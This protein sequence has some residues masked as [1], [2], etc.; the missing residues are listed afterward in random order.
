MTQAQCVLDIS[1]LYCIKCV[2][3]RGHRSSSAYLAMFNVGIM[4]PAT[5]G[6]YTCVSTSLFNCLLIFIDSADIATCY[7]TVLGL[8]SVSEMNVVINLKVLLLTQMVEFHL[9]CLYIQGVVPGGGGT[10][11]HCCAIVMT[12]NCIPGIPLSRR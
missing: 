3:W 1:E 7:N 2:Q 6:R 8:V 4:C 12:I 11:F 5:D 10:R 9:P